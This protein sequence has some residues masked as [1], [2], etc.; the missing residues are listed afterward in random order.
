LILSISLQIV[1]SVFGSRP[2]R[3]FVMIVVVMPVVVVM[4]VNY[5]NH[6]CLSRIR[7]RDAEK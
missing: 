5:H 2:S 1:N 6:L 4:V 7:Y 3:L